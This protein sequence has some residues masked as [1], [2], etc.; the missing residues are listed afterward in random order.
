MIGVDES[1]RLWE[2][3]LKIASTVEEAVDLDDTKIVGC[4]DGEER[5]YRVNSDDWSER[6]IEI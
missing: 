5:T 6:L 3:Y 2:V 4:A 1:F